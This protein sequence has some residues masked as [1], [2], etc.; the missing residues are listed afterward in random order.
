MSKLPQPLRNVEVA[1]RDGARRRVC[2]WEAV[3]R[4]SRAWRAAAGCWC[5]PRAR[6][7]WCA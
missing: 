6:S 3:E 7:R 1:D 5:V 4:E 2:G